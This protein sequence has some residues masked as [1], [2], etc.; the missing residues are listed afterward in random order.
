MKPPHAKKSQSGFTLIEVLL[1]LIIIA[2]ALTALIKAIAQNVENTHRIKQKTIS[3]W[4][5]M[6]GVALIQLGLLQINPNQETTQET[7]ML[8]THWFW[9]AKVSATPKKSVELITLSVSTQKSGPF[10]E[11]LY[12][13]RYV[14]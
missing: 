3:H 10:R 8:G 7:F 5:A 11:E 1:A 4:V 2:I 12:A 14:R 6:Q 9:R 13:F